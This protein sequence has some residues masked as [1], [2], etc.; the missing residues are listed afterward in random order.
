MRNWLMRLLHIFLVASNGYRYT[1]GTVM[2]AGYG[3][4]KSE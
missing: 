1:V 2:G 4:M 3:V